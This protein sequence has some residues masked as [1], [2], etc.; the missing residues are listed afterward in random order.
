M[1]RN[2]LGELKFEAMGEMKGRY[3]LENEMQ[4]RDS[5]SASRRTRGG[6]SGSTCIGSAIEGRKT[7]VPIATGAGAP[8]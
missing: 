1:R 6:R 2:T 3:A 4:R 8:T 7:T 5:E